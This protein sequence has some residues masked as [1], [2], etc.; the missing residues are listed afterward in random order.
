MEGASPYTNILHRKSSHTTLAHCTVDSVMSSLEKMEPANSALDTSSQ[1]RQYPP[2]TT[3]A[4][5][6]FPRWPVWTRHATTG[7]LSHRLP[8]QSLSRLCIRSHTITGHGCG[9]NN[10][11]ATSAQATTSV[12]DTNENE[13]PLCKDCVGVQRVE[14]RLEELSQ[15]AR[16]CTSHPPDFLSRHRVDLP[17]IAVSH[18]AGRFSRVYTSQPV[19]RAS[20]TFLYRS[21]PQPLRSTPWARCPTSPKM[22]LAAVSKKIVAFGSKQVF[23]YAFTTRFYPQL[24][25]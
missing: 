9:R 2:P 1:A 12:Q 19:N 3:H 6:S 14:M 11:L 16:R 17:R 24:L 21:T 15:P 5:Q 23:L 10:P 8:I 20:H 4:A 18:A 22:D 7:I 25:I 13:V